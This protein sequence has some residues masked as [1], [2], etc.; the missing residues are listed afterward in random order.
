MSLDN[1]NIQV[2]RSVNTL[3]E[4]GSIQYEDEQRGLKLN[5]GE[6]IF[7]DNIELDNE[8]PGEL[9]KVCDAYIVVG[10]K[11]QYETDEVTINNSPVFKALSQQR[12]NN[13]VFYDTDQETGGGC[14]INEA[15][16]QLPVNRLT[17]ID[18][19]PDDLSDSDIA[20]YYILCQS[21]DD[22]VVYKFTLDDAGIYINGR[23]IMKG[24]AWNDYAETRVL[25]GQALPG[26]V[27]CDTGNGTVKLSEENYQAC[28]HIVSDTYGHLIGNKN[29]DTVPIAVAGR[30]LISVNEEVKL[31][32][33]ICAGPNGIGK[34]MTRQEIISYPD[35]IIGVVCEIPKTEYVDSIAVNG[36]VWVNVK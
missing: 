19:T 30:V 21:E 12:A 10:R 31:G 5:F 29:D 16:E 32:D 9:G 7:V 2:K 11:P 18:I 6:P 34:K 23:G 20:K 33:C 26:Q 24:A 17:T 22:N 15:G 14:I 4:L 1:T 13:L 36:R 25:E 3:E 28:A 8:K 35:R 27:V